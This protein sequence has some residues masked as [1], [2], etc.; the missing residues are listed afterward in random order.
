MNLGWFVGELLG[1][2]MGLLYGK[3]WKRLRRIFDPAFTRSAALARV[4]V[5][6]CAARKYVE[7]LHLLADKPP[8]SAGGE[9]DKSFSL[10]VLKA[11]TKF[12]YFL[13]ASTIYGPMTEVEER[14]LWSV[15]EK[16]IALNQYWLGGGAYRFESLAKWFDPG[17]V[18]RLKEFNAEWHNYNARMVEVRRARGET[19]PIITYWEEYEKGNMALVEVSSLIRLEYLELQ[20]QC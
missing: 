16:R 6:D 1:Q 11:F 2:A 18:Q 15:T 4:D 5:V 19:A 17:A 7:G 8:G 3:D 12:P 14:D 20:G 9:D 13:T 10:P